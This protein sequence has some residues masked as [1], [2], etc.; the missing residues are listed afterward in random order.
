MNKSDDQNYEEEKCHETRE[1]AVFRPDPA[2]LND[3]RVVAPSTS[4]VLCKCDGREP[5]ASGRY[6]EG[7]FLRNVAGTA[8]FTNPTQVVGSSHFATVKQLLNVDRSW[9]YHAQ[10]PAVGS[11]SPGSDNS[12]GAVPL[13]YAPTPAG[14]QPVQPY[15]L[16]AFLHKGKAVS[17]CSTSVAASPLEGEPELELAPSSDLAA[18]LSLPDRDEERHPNDVDGDWILYCGLSVSRFGKGNV[19]MRHGLPL[20]AR[21]LAIYA[22]NVC[23]ER[24]QLGRTL[25]TR[26]AG[27][28]MTATSLITDWFVGAPKSAL[29]LWQDIS[30]S[31]RHVIVSESRQDPDYFEVSPDAEL[32]V[33]V[34]YDLADFTSRRGSFDLWV[35]VVD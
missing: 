30:V 20:C 28:A 15:S 14:M 18:A 34:N 33:Q 35:K 1:F 32:L 25:V 11:A 6:L 16:T 23:W 7:V 29:V 4:G 27:E 9:S 22:A 2:V 3:V 8:P 5:A 12:F 10:L 24:G 21:R 26:A 31:S 19:L 13:I 17:Q